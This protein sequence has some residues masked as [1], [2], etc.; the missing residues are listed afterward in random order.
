MEF[1]E[2]H[3]RGDPKEYQQLMQDFSNIKEQRRKLALETVGKNKDEVL[4][5]YQEQVAPYFD[6]LD[7]TLNK[8][9][10][11]ADARSA[12]IK[13]Q[14]QRLIDSVIITTCLFGLLLVGFLWYVLNSEE[15][16]HKAIRHREQL[17]NILSH[18]VDEVFIIF[19]FT[20]FRHVLNLDSRK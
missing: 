12:E 11:N 14:A 2:H 18:T 8:V 3:F 19:T 7:K 6:V 16:A 10:A 9:S 17:F 13:A 5:M 20:V 15:R 1:L 4:R